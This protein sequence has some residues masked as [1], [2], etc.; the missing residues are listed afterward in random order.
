MIHNSDIGDSEGWVPTDK[1][2]MH[3]AGFDDAYAIGDATNIPISKTGV[4]AHLQANAVAKTIF[5]DIEES[6]VEYKFNGRINCPF[7]T[8]GGK[9]T[10]V[11]ATYQSP[12]KQ[13]PPSRWNYI[14]KRAFARMYWS[15]LSGRWEPIFGLYFGETA[16]ETVKRTPILAETIPTKAAG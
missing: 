6:P 7:E 4:V 2:T 5:A 14:Q 9:S 13:I 15:T 3:A 10:F 12:P 16:E 8:G 11:I 1:F